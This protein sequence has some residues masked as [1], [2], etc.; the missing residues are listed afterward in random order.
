MINSQIQN[1]IPVC[2]HPTTVV[3]VDDNQSLLDSIRLSLVD[4][5]PCREFTLAKDALDFLNLS[6]EESFLKRCLKVSKKSIHS[7]EHV[8][9]H[10]K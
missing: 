2:Y 10:L 6:S 9:V 5:I 4:S 1:F 7:D 3:L 8:E